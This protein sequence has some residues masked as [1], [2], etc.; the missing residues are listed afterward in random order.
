[1]R[2]RAVVLAAAIVLAPLGAR[3]ADLVVWWDEGYYAEEDQALREVIA[4]FEQESGKGGRAGLPSDGGTAGC[5]TAAAL[6]AGQPPDFAF[7][8]WL[9]DYAPQW[10]LEDR[11]VD[12]S[13]TIGHFSDLFDPA[14]LDRGHAA[15]C[16]HG[17]KSSVRPADRS[18][19]P[20]HARLEEPPGGG[21]FHP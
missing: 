10:A 16:N 21:R 4:A 15:Q 6:E 17:P 1:M 11:L 13:D 9:T 8:F 5:K 7:G 19:H 12:L 14:Q 20:P 18:D 2:I 3:A